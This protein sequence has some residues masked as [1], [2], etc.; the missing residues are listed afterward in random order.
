MRDDHR[1]E[2]EGS[3]LASAV[4][5]DVDDDVERAEF[6]GRAR[7]ANLDGGA[8]R[9]RPRVRFDL[10][11]FA[12]PAFPLD[13]ERRGARASVSH[14]E[15]GGDGVAEGDDAEVEVPGD[16]DVAGW[17][18]SREREFRGAHLGLDDARVPEV[19][20]LVRG[21]RHLEGGGESR[22]EPDADEVVADEV[23]SLRL[24]RDDLD[25]VRARVGVTQRH[26]GG[27]HGVGLGVL[28]THRGGKHP[29]PRQRVRPVR[30][31][32]VLQTKEP[33]AHL[34][35]RGGVGSADRRSNGNYRG[36]ATSNPTD[37]RAREYRGARRSHP[38]ARR[39]ARRPRVRD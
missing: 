20:L 2:R 29:Q 27:V 19:V 3:S 38:F 13:V 23:E 31:G 7:D 4:D 33:R 1:G 9:H 28:E 21:E 12:V 32:S 26:L 11:L 18:A 8:A 15:R 39:S 5:G 10:H 34:G 17:R 37:E 30:R 24:R 25:R 14:D 35:P 22:G 16:D 6:D 36:D